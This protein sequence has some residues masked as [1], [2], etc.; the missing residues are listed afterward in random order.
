MYTTIYNFLA[1]LVIATAAFG[2]DHD[3]PLSRSRARNNA[4]HHSLAEKRQ[5]ATGGYAYAGCVTDGSARVLT[6][7]NTW[8]TSMTV[9][10]CVTLCSARD[11]TYAGLQSESSLTIDLCGKKLMELDGNQCF[12]RLLCS[13][14][15]MI[16]T[17]SAAI[18]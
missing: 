8:S 18:H 17:G 5:V 10:D 7:S 1:V 9:D 3:S 4:R 15:V 14:E 6:G 2:A 13:D 11:Y 16:L 12:V